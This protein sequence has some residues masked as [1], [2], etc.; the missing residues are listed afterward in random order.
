MIKYGK[1]TIEEMEDRIEANLPHGSGINYDWEIDIKNSK[2]VVCK[3]AYDRMDE[4]GFYD[5]IFPFKVIFTP[6]GFNVHFRD[7]TPYG[8]RLAREEMLKSYLEDIFA[9]FYDNIELIMNW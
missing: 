7:L 2:Y 4:N 1:A 5:G 9:E 6:N 8:Y 3:N